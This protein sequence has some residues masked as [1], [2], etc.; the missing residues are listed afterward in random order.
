MHTEFHERGLFSYNLTRELTVFRIDLRDHLKTLSF[1]YILPPPN[2]LK[3]PSG[4][5]LELKSPRPR[6]TC[7]SICLC[8][9]LFYSPIALRGTTTPVV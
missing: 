7:K 9:L 5:Y 4:N 1:H 6:F 8:S 3:D 2:V